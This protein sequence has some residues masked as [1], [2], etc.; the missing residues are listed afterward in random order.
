MAYPI[1]SSQ[2]MSDRWTITRDGGWQLRKAGRPALLLGGQVHNSSSSSL[3][4]IVKSFAHARTMNAN[5]VVAPVSWALTEPEEGVFDFTLVDGML[6][7]ARRNDLRLVIL[8]FGAF[9]NAGSMYAPRWVRADRARFPRAVIESKG[10]HAFSYEGATAKPV[11]SVFGGELR[12][13]DAAAFEGLMAHLVSADLEDT[14]AMV[15]IEN[16]SGLLSDS[17][18]R[19]AP[20]LDAWN[21]EVPPELLTHLSD[22]ADADSMGPTLWRERGSKTTGTW[23]E[24][25]GDDLRADEVFMAWAFARYVEHLA[26]RGKAIKQVPMFVNAWLGPQPGQDHPGQYPSGGPASRVLDIW[27]AAAPSVDLLCPDIYVDDADS[28]MRTY[29]TG[30]QPLFV[31]ECRLSAGEL[32]RAIWTYH[33]VGWS[34]FGLDSANPDGQV[35]ATLG[36][37]TALEAL[38]IAAGREGRLG[39][40]VIEPSD[41]LVELRIGDFDV[42][43]RGAL[44]LLRRILL[45]AGVQA[46]SAAQSLADETLAGAAMAHSADTRPFGL[47]LAEDRDALIVV[48]QGLTV[49]FVSSADQV[50]I[51][52]VEELLVEGGSIAVGRILGGDERLRVVPTDRVGAARIRLLRT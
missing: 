16:E 18:D 30:A 31:P 40:V 22:N 52:S 23:V 44:A 17:R 1:P 25:L 10:K 3:P 47:L 27:R 34:A 13:A 41:E 26:A 12:A 11:L 7:E 33:A 4:S 21:A 49:D 48:G 24:V 2:P 9:K 15:Q 14:V 29:A 37:L 46:P 43:A 45:D 35:A 32:V 39:A 50:E 51:D 20:A 38:I 6:D 5:T 28:A 8:W 19:S 42:T 36:Y